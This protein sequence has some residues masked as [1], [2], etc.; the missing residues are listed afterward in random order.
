[1]GLYMEMGYF[2]DGEFAGELIPTGIGA[3]MASDELTRDDFESR[4]RLAV[5][6]DEAMFSLDL[7][8]DADGVVDSIPL[9]VEGFQAITGEQVEPERYRAHHRKAHSDAMARI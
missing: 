2:D 7:W 4:R 8:D 3:V 6:V 9:S 5:P 1:M